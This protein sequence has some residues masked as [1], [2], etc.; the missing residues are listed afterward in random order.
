M[1]ARS[2]VRGA[3]SFTLLS[4]LFWSLA[5]TAMAAE[6]EEAPAPSAESTEGDETPP[7]KTVKPHATEPAP[8]PEPAP[9][10]PA[11]TPAVELG[12]FAGWKVSFNGR[13]NAFYSYG[14]GNQLVSNTPE[15]APLVEGSGVGL[16]DNQT[17][18]NGNFHTGRIRNGF[19]PNVFSVDIS[20]NLTDTTTMLAHLALWSDIETNLSVYIQAQTYMQEGYLRLE[21][22]WGQFTA[23]RQLALFS[24]GAVDI[25]FLYAHGNG[26]GWP[27]N[28]NFIYATCGQIGFGVLFPFFRPGFMYTTPSLGGLTL[29]AAAF[30]PAILAGKWE[31]VVM[32]TLQA[33]AAFTTKIGGTGLFK[34]FVSGLFQRLS[35]KRDFPNLVNKH[36]DQEGVAGGMRLEIGPMRLGLA[37][38]YGKGLG[39]YY[40]QENSGA[41]AYNATNL[42]DPVDAARDGDLRTFRGF[43]GQLAGFFGPFMLAAGAGVSQLIPLAWETGAALPPLPK[44]NLGINGVFNYFI[45]DNLI[46]DIDFFRA[47]FTWYATTFTQN[48]NAV[49][50]GITMKF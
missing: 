21:G 4:S 28:F 2:G 42:A 30:D 3:V 37:G 50:T 34:L 25:D 8:A 6:E 19:V 22:P 33:E 27:C 14:W 38:H 24:R 9:A 39:F 31:R 35:A 36:V 18:A 29:T 26:L 20:R 48:V 1:R 5:G 16:N 41:A 40:A 7:K 43:Y 13:V 46:F 15:G 49:N 12:T 23:G 32:P 45:S 47:Q 10:A 17:D 11:K 44:Q